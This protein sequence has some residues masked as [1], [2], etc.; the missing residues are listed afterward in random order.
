MNKYIAECIGT[1]VLVLSVCGTAVMSAAYP[2]VGVG[3]FGV[4]CAAGLAVLA[5]AYAVGH[6][7]GGHFNPAVTIGLWAGGRF[8]VKEI[9][10][11]IISQVL[12]ATL[13]G[14]V[15]Y[16]IASG[17][18]GFSLAG[19]F[20]ATGYGEHSPGGY[21]L[22]AAFICEFIFTAIFLFV[23]MGV[24][25]KKAAAGFAP[26]AIGLCLVVIHLAAIPVS[27]ASVNP[28]RSTG[29]ALYAGGWAI[30]ELWMFWVAPIAGGI[31]GALTY[32]TLNSKQSIE[33]STADIE[34]GLSA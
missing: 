7:S 26:I 19:G 1:F 20:A 30:V 21:S 17:Q 10:P 27:N 15:L 31:V 4:A 18:T 9:V 34:A 11:Y 32:R 2:E 33:S 6:I 23:I 14:G 5:M 28:A 3:F 22:V 8:N 16:L 12:G 25:D 13:A 24:T 29:V